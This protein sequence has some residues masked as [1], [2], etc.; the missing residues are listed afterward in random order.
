MKKIGICIKSL[1]IGG[2]ERLL[3]DIIKIISKTNKYKIKLLTEKENL[4]SSYYQ[5]I[6][7]KIEYRYLLNNR[8]NS[9][10]GIF[11]K[12]IKSLMKQHRFKKFEKDLDI[13]IDFL[14]ADFFKYIKK[15]KNKK[16][17]TWLH[18]DYNFLKQRKKV[19]RKLDSYDEIITITKESF[20]EIKKLYPQKVVKQIYNVIDFERIEKKK[21]ESID[22]KEKYFLTVCR[23]NESEKDV[24]TLIEAFSK[25][26][27]TEKLYIIGDGK[28]KKNLEKKVKVKGL[29][30]K[31]RFLGKKNNPYSY[32]K[33]AE[34][35]ILS[36]KVEGFGIVLAEALFSG[37]KVISSD[38]KTGPREILLDGKIG[39]LFLVGDSNDLL[40]KINIAKNKEYDKKEIEDS[41]KRFEKDNF[42]KKIERELV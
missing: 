31:V 30:E 24:S 39:E 33:N 36:S 20:K 41:L 17:I 16:K 12:L 23:L 21:Y 15:V 40:E 13:I 37:T 7:D 34:L 29:E 4:A 38:C 1:E 11:S 9:Y 19:D 25:Y 8:E 35:F 32:M 10:S 2:A 42:I 28:D 14:D 5:E 27:G 26:T 6:K 3:T 18:S 22:I